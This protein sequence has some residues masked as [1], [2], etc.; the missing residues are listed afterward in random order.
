MIQSIHIINPSGSWLSMNVGTNDEVESGIK[1]FSAE[2][3]GPPKAVISGLGGPYRDGLLVNSVRAE[4]RYITLTMVAYPGGSS[5]QQ[6]A[7]NEAYE[8]FPIKGYIKIRVAGEFG[9]RDIYGYVE[10]F[11]VNQW[12]KIENYV[13][14]IYCTDPWF[15]NYIQTNTQ[16]KSGGGSAV[17]DYTGDVPTGVEF[18][19]NINASAAVYGP[20]TIYNTGTEYGDAPGLQT[21][22]FDTHVT[23]VEPLLNG[24]DLI[25]TTHQG[26]KSLIHKRGTTETN[27]ISQMGF[28]GEWPWFYPGN[29]TCGYTVNVGPASTNLYAKFYKLY[30]GV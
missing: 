19:I 30:Q 20:Y 18:T 23:G 9:T 11:V 16:I 24:D 25:L 21:F 17:Y 12:A 7:I 27:L 5:G 10:N 4:G 8:H 1:L 22:S 13:A 3:F 28:D 29:N 6:D 15:Q 2:G 26:Q 14:T